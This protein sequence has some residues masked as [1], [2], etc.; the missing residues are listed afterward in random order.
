VGRHCSLHGAPREALAECR[1]RRAGCAGLLGQVGR[2]WNWHLACARRRAGYSMDLAFVVATV[3]FFAASIAYV[4]GC[5][6]L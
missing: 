5:D 3:A 4:Y 1:A 6:H 2:A